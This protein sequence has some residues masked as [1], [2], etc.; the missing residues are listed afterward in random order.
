MPVIQNLRHEIWLPSSQP[1]LKWNIVAEYDPDM[2]FAVWLNTTTPVDT[3]GQ[4]DMTINCFDGQ[5]EY[6]TAY[7]Q[8]EN[9]YVAAPDR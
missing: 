2:R 5:G 7:T 6:Q 1:V 4:P 8:T 3:A 9:C